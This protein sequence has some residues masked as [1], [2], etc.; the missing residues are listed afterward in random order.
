MFHLP[1]IGG[2]VDAVLRMF[3]FCDVWLLCFG[4]ATCAPAKSNT[5]LKKNSKI[6]R[7]KLTSYNRA[8]GII[9][10]PSMTNLLSF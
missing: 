6:S 9:L 1:S 4:Y 3:G 5:G 10:H 2:G 8:H 7:A